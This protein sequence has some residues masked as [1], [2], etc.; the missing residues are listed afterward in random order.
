MSMFQYRARMASVAVAMFFLAGA[1][2]G[3]EPPSTNRIVAAGDTPVT[4]GKIIPDFKD[5][6]LF[7]FAQAVGQTSGRTIVVGPGVCA[8]VSARWE[9]PLTGQQ[10]YEEFVSITRT[11]GF[12]IVEQGSVTTITLDE[13]SRK[14]SQ[15]RCRRYPDTRT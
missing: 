9:T 5:A 6:D 14:D 1:A 8:V 12:V 15:P 3:G 11:L 10:F 2:W 13:N 4:S 7:L